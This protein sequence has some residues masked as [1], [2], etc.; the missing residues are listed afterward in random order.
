MTE[1]PNILFI[2]SDQ[3][4]W[5]A[6]GFEDPSFQ[7]PNLDQR[8]S[9]RFETPV[10]RRAILFEAEMHLCPVSATADTRRLRLNGF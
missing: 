4:H 9:E 10:C 7:T 3:Q 1:K 2:F 6:L 5:Q 8:A